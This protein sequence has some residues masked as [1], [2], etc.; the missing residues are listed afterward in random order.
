MGKLDTLA[1]EMEGERGNEERAYLL[2][3]EDHD[4]HKDVLTLMINYLL[5]VKYKKV[6]YCK[7]W[8]SEVHMVR[9]GRWSYSEKQKGRILATCHD[10]LS[11]LIST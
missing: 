2:K 9:V 8:S 1:S 3:E 11:R 10:Y 5:K 4:R 7:A 6:E